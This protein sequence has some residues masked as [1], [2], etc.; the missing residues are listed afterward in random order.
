MWNELWMGY[1]IGP[2]YA[3]QSNVTNA[4]RL[5]GELMLVVG[6]LD[7]NVDRLR[8]CRWQCFAGGDKDFELLFMTGMGH[9]ALGSPYAK[10]RM[11]EF[12][13]KHLHPE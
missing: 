4:H 11:W 12:F 9:G 5:Q 2:H 13:I 8:R 10:R 6:E 3:E 7:D 1:P